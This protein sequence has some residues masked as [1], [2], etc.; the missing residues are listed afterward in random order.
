M[1]G[2]RAR[3]HGLSN[4]TWYRKTNLLLIFAGFLNIPFFV[5]IKQIFFSSESSKIIIC[6]P[7]LFSVFFSYP[8]KNKYLPKFF[9]PSFCYFPSL[10]FYSPRK[11]GSKSNPREQSPALRDTSPWDEKNGK[12]KYSWFFISDDG[13]KQFC[14][15]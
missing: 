7:T 10:G 3:L 5:V 14:Y 8:R 12:K 6:F 13:K 2:S 1:W 9:L 11:L 15:F 4:G